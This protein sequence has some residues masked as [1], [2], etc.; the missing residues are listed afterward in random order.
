MRTVFNIIHARC[1][2]AFRRVTGRSVGRSTVGHQRSRSPWNKITARALL[3]ILARTSPPRERLP[4]IIHIYDRTLYQPHLPRI[5]LIETSVSEA[6]GCEPR[7]LRGSRAQCSSRAG[8]RW[9]P[10]SILRTV[11]RQSGRDHLDRRAC[12]T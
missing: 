8:A 9:S 2:L 12:P 10:R 3:P 1:I 5:H 4:R 6:I 7:C 11:V